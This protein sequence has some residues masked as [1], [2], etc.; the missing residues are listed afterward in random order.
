[1]CL[2]GLTQVLLSEAHVEQVI[3]QEKQAEIVFPEGVDVF[4]AQI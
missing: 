1:M 3:E 4:V 2:Q